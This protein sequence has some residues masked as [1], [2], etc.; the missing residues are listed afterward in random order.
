MGILM[1][2]LGR[3]CAVRTLR[4]ARDLLE[5]AAPLKTDCGRLCEKACCQSDESGEN[6]MQLFPYEEV[7]YQRTSEDFPFRLIPD[8]SVRKGGVRLVCEGR[9][10][11][12]LRPL[13]CRLFP[14]RLRVFFDELGAH[15]AADPE[16]D[17][18]AWAL[19]PLAEQERLNALDPSFLSAVNEA[20]ALL[21]KNLFHLE[22]LVRE[23]AM[24]DEARRL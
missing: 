21:V 8:N 16:I 11:R 1:T 10:L 23:Q 14:L 9:C 20:G 22:F 13:A 3:P 12:E 19:C 18:R 7:L 2:W 15:A 24:L 17:P 4:A 6:G 5:T